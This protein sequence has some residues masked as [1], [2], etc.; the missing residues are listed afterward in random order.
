MRGLAI[1]IGYHRGALGNGARAASF[2]ASTNRTDA[3]GQCTLTESKSGASWQTYHRSPGHH[4]DGGSLVEILFGRSAM[5]WPRLYGIRGQRAILEAHVALQFM[6]R[7]RLRT[8]HYVEGDGLMG[9]AAKA[10]D[11]EIEKPALSPSPNAGDGRA[12]P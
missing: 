5:R 2:R 7:R 3:G 9:V 4:V 11:F 6:D 8:T 1:P 12:G 10:F